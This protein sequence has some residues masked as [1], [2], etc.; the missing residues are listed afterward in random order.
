MGNPNNGFPIFCIFIYKKKQMTSRIKKIISEEIERFVLNE[1]LSSKCYH[2]TTLNGLLRI[3]KTN[4]FLLK[5]DVVSDTEHWADK[6]RHRFF[7]STTRVRNGKYGY[8]HFIKKEDMLVRITLNGDLLNANY[9]GMPINWQMHSEKTRGYEPN[10]RSA[11]SS[12]SRAM[13]NN[14]DWRLAQIQPFVENEDRIFSSKPTIPNADRY[15]ERIDILTYISKDFVDIDSQ[16]LD[17]LQ[18]IPSRFRNITR[19]Y[20]TMKDF[21]RQDNNADKVDRSKVK[22]TIYPKV[23]VNLSQEDLK[24]IDLYGKSIYKFFEDYD[25]AIELVNEEEYDDDLIDSLYKDSQS[26]EEYIKKLNTDLYNSKKSKQILKNVSDWF[27]R[28]KIANFKDLLNKIDKISEL[29]LDFKYAH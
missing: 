8:N 10:L 9:R 17:I 25:K 3:L 20:T 28:H 1:M 19:I 4:S 16:A 2:F 12:K 13:Y 11:E 29:F 7:M 26:C 5:T 27:V 18:D 23:D 15:I 14:P 21:N 22:D 6:P 24:Q